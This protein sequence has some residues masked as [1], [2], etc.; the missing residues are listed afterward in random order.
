MVFITVIVKLCV[1]ASVCMITGNFN[2]FGSLG[3]CNCRGGKSFPLEI[4]TNPFV[5]LFCSHK[6]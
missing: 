6:C 2:A 4:D 1:Q 5:V 3:S